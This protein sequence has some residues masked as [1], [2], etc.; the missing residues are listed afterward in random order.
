MNKI[1][2]GIIALMTV[3]T[4]GAT[5]PVLAAN[6]T[7]AKDCVGAGLNAA[8]GNANGTTTDP[9]TIIKTIVNA[10]LYVLGAV[11]VIM[12]VLGGIK[13]TTSNGDASAVTSAKNTI[14]YAVIGLLVAIFAYAIVNFVVT[15]F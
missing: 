11:A 3:I 7:S 6:C 14:L 5:S 13:Y 10:L 2:V 4:L 12:I 9:G 15:R 8:G 1:K